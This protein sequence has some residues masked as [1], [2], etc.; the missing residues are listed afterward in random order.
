MISLWKY[1]VLLESLKIAS[2]ILLQINKSI[3]PNFI[4][5]TTSHINNMASLGK[6]HQLEVVEQLERGFYLTFEDKKV[7]LP[8]N[9]VRQDIK[10]GDIVK[11]F[12]YKDSE[13]RLI[14]TQETPAGEVGEFVFLKVKDTNSIGAF[15]GWGLLKDLLVPFSEQ[16]KT[17]KV[18]DECV[19]VIVHDK[20]S[21]RLIGVTKFRTFF[22][23][24]IELEENQKVQL[25]VYHIT[26]MGYM[27]VIDNK[28]SGLLYKNEV[29]ERLKIGDKREGFVKKV[30]EDGKID[31]SLQPLGY[32]QDFMSVQAT[33]I[34]EMLKNSEGFLP[35]HDK[36]EAE[37]IEDIFQMSKNQFKKALGFLYKQKKIVLE[38]RGIRLLG[39][40]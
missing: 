25:L 11:V 15:M 3:L 5:F 10:V 13:D 23:R 33:K 26:E 19:V 14:A 9:C 28:Y 12:L 21:D 31:L 22:S 40:S 36:S 7:L 16:E 1:F 29:K 4:T 6:Y 38:N 27:C 37:D 24:L 39:K 35:Y 30:R 17:L 32:S 8:K 20:K 18:G 2:I 34:L